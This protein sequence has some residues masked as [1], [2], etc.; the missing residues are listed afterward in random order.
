[1]TDYTYE[2]KLANQTP[3]EEILNAFNSKSIRSLSRGIKQAYKWTSIWLKDPSNAVLVSYEF[4]KYIR[5]YVVSIAANYFVIKEIIDSDLGFDFFFR[6]NSNKSY[7]YLV[8]TDKDKTFELTLNQTQK[9]NRCAPSSHFRDDL[10][11]KYES[12][13]FSSDNEVANNDKRY[14]QLTHGYQTEEPGFINLGIPKKDGYW[15]DYIDISQLLQVT[16]SPILKT[17]ALEY[18]SL[19]LSK[20]QTYI[21]EV[22]KNE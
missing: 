18:K 7:P 1:M 4:E 15:R 9:G 21:N 3:K 5:G 22:V 20:M 12:S 6:Y 8:I 2:F 13:L 10:I 11:D 17:K 16:E 19:D 14:F